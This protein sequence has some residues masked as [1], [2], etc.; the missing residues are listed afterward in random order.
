[1]KKEFVVFRNCLWGVILKSEEEGLMQVEYIKGESWFV[2]TG[3]DHII[4]SE[5][6]A[7]FISLDEFNK[8]EE[9]AYSI[10]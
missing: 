9:L 10:I 5:S 8:R 4:I 1:M 7:E 6:E 2:P 3:Y